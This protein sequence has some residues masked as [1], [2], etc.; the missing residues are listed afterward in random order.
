LR[1]GFRQHQISTVCYKFLVEGGK[2]LGEEKTNLGRLRIMGKAFILWM[3]GVP[4][5][6]ILALW[7]FGFLH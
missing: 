6:V 4:G 2:P 7:M 3:L 5:G 1:I